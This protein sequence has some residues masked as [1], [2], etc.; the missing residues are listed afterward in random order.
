MFMNFDIKSA[1]SVEEQKP[2]RK[3]Q[4]VWNKKY[5][6]SRKGT[7]HCLK[8]PT[9]YRA[10]LQVPYDDCLS[11]L[12]DRLAQAERPPP[13][14][15]LEH[16]RQVAPPGSFWTVWI[17]TELRERF[18]SAKEKVGADLTHG[19]FMEVLLNLEIFMPGCVS[20]SHDDSF[21]KL[22]YGSM[23]LEA[24]ACEESKDGVGNSGRLP[25]SSPSRFPELLPSYDEQK[26]TIDTAHNTDHI[27]I[28]SN[29]P[30]PPRTE[31]GL[32]LS[33][34]PISDANAPPYCPMLGP[35]ETTEQLP[36]YLHSNSNDENN[37]VND[38]DFE[39][40][41]RD[42]RHSS[43][44]E[45]TTPYEIAVPSLTWDMVEQ[46]KSSDYQ[47]SAEGRFISHSAVHDEPLPSY[48]FSV[49]DSDGESGVEKNSELID[50]DI[51]EFEVP[52]CFQEAG[53]AHTLYDYE[54]FDC[55]L[56]AEYTWTSEPCNVPFTMMDG[57]QWHPTHDYVAP[58][59]SWAI[60]DDAD[61]QL[62]LSRFTI[63]GDDDPTTG[64]LEVLQV[65]PE[66]KPLSDRSPPW[67]DRSHR[68]DSLR[69]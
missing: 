56:G 25:A 17:S 49:G 14:E 64:D 33:S 5:E 6:N 28:T 68:S 12:L 27:G 47:K 23:K 48:E 67:R 66:Y 18:R 4:D 21:P 19:A 61:A 9:E 50:M 24:G 51:D 26:P 8:L 69:M 46:T 55:E 42:R 58:P 59:L 31:R 40:E 54:T 37:S 41:F 3:R 36:P 45:A 29:S 52:I 13:R 16:A 38:W 65:E 62:L 32:Q 15:L 39:A 63:L 35:G 44:V 7:R 30:P 11:G 60:D 1:S 34:N 57:S 22:A 10:R 43:L 53:P 20:R 2:R